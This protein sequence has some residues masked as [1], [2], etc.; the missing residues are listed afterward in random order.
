MGTSRTNSN[1]HCD[2]CPSNI[3]PGGICPYQTYLSC[4]YMNNDIK[5]YYYIIASR[6]TKCNQ[7]QCLR[8]CQLLLTGSKTPC[9]GCFISQYI[10]MSVR[11]SSR[12]AF[13]RSTGNDVSGHYKRHYFLFFLFLLRRLLFS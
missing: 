1:C 7:L 9:I 13:G 2:L 10:G 12:S 6:W 4:Y 8:L 11:R 5:S 3:C